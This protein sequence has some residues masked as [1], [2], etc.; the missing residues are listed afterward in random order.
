M[1]AGTPPFAEGSIV[2]RLMKHAR[3]E[4]ADLRTIN[5]EVPDE[6]WAVCRR[7]LEKKPSQ[8][9]QTPAELLADLVQMA[10]R[11]PA[12]RPPKAIANA[13]TGALRPTKVADSAT[14]EVA[15]AG[16]RIVA[17]Q[18]EHG[19]HAIATGNYDY[20][21]TLLLTCCRLDPGNLA[22]HQGLRQAQRARRAAAELRPWRSWPMQLVLKGWLKAAQQLGQPLRVLECARQLLTC[23]PDDLATQLDMAKA[24]RR[25]DFDELAVWLLETAL[26][27]HPEDEAVMRSLAGLYEN[28]G[29]IEQALALWEAIAR[30]NPHQSDPARKVRNLAAR[31][32]S[33]KYRAAHQ[34]KRAGGGGSAIS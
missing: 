13:G 14:Q 34:S 33:G 4:P 28:V 19:A 24:A 17:S 3:A 22:L 1:L 5:A 10:P 27:A 26:A 11:S 20:G 18:F 2:E 7:L 32:T 25:A 6:L 21:M 8:R 9:Y 23:N 30:N 12:V 29:K 15:P 16:Q 31:V